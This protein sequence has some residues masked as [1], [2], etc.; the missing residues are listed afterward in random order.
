LPC[1]RNKRVTVENLRQNGFIVS[2]E[3][4][5]LKITSHRILQLDWRKI[6]V[7]ETMYA[8]LRVTADH[9]VMVSCSE[10]KFAAD[11]VAG[12]AV[13]CTSGCTR[14]TNVTTHFESVEAVEISFE[15]DLPFEAW[16]V[17]HASILS[18]GSPVAPG[19]HQRK[20]TRRGGA[21]RH[22]RLPDQDAVDG[23]GFFSSSSA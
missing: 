13:Q 17:P 15:P 9:R 18:K 21:A 3:G 11:F 6:V 12:D 2:P 4:V 20:A 8:I 22:R 14:L 5:P 1:S 10:F 7:L 19:V 23:A 16:M